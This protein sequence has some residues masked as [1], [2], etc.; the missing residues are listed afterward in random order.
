MLPLETKESGSKTLPHS[1]LRCGGVSV[2]RGGIMQE[3]KAFG[4]TKT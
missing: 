3:E 2:S 1:D 4:E